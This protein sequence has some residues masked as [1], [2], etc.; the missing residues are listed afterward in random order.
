MLYSKFSH[1]MCYHDTEKLNPLWV[2]RLTGAEYFDT[3][4]R[5]KSEMLCEHSDNYFE[6]KDSTTLA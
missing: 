2:F 1:N 5:V 6:V 3:F 4:V